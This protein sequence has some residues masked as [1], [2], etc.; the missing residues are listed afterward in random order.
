M[1]RGGKE[2]VKVSEQRREAIKKI[3]GFVAG[4]VLGISG[5]N[6]NAQEKEQPIS[7]PEIKLP[8]P[9]KNEDPII[10]MMRDLQR[11]LKKPI[12]QRKWTM[13]IDTRKCV[14]CNACTISCIAEN[15]LPPGVVYRPVIQEEVGEYPHVRRR[16]IPRPCMQCE[17]PPCTDVCPVDATYKRPDGV[18]VVDY[19][20]CIGCRYC[21]T[22]C[23]Y[24]AR[25]FDWGEFY[26]KGV[27]IHGLMPYEKVNSHEYGVEWKRPE[28]KSPVGNV[29]KCHFC[30][31]R[32]EKGLLP[33]CVTT[34]IGRA[35]YFGD[36]SDPQ[37]LVAELIGQPNVMRLK[38][39]LGTKPSVYYLT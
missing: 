2:N 21:I 17:E 26:T 7:I 23:P 32:V 1:K 11:A 35:T 6:I 28:G 10:R 13:V 30:I 18:V 34:C 22:A 29:R 3:L 25:T 14:G 38:E 5:N 36:R 33:M 37:S 27:G 8:P 4:S 20:I 24:N 9:Q 19:N 15:R 16:F 12:E 39:E 31:H